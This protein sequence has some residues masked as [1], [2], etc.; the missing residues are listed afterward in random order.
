MDG[1]GP[2]ITPALVLV[3]GHNLLWRA[4]FGFPAKVSARDG[5]DRTAV[6]AFFALLRVALRQLDQPVECIICFDG[7]F[8]AQWRQQA[9]QTY[10]HN[11]QD[12]DLSP[13]V[14]L[15][16]IQR[17]L[18]MLELSWVELDHEEADDVIA[19]L[20]RLDPQWPTFVLSTDRDYLQLVSEHVRVLNTA[21]RS[22]NH[23]LGPTEVFD[24]YG[25]HPWQWC[26]FR[27]LTG[28]PADAI[29]GVPG[30]GV[31]TAAKL[32]ADGATLETLKGSDR[33]NG[34][35]GQRIVECW[36]QVLA[37]RD[38]IQLRD[39]IELPCRPV[40]VE[41]NPLP[42]PATILEELKLW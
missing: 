4:A 1:G 16:D 9:D 41:T 2:D 15:P 33:L 21:M 42:A 37:W 3:D 26:D 19:S 10:K 20:V 11:R 24:R 13:L 23:L 25:V 18:S 30:V 22:G 34:R 12:I 31:R 6:F 17:G 14:G 39:T 40:R 36:D 28:H 8:G 32:L 35:I 7:Q 38:L 29:A 27:A 5:T